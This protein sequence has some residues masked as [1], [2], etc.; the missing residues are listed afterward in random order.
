MA[1]IGKTYRQSSEVWE[2]IQIFKKFSSKCR[3]KKLGMIH[4]ILGSFCSFLYW[5]GT[6]IRPHIRRRKI[7]DILNMNAGLG[8]ACM[9]IVQAFS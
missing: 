3:T 7:P 8:V 1:L 2:I 5:E 6:D 4:T 9:Y